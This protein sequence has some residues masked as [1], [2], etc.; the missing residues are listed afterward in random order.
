MK[1]KN[2]KKKNKTKQRCVDC[3]KERL[4]KQKNLG[5]LAFWI[6]CSHVVPC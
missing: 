6:F 1:K 4:E 2:K 5:G 3:H